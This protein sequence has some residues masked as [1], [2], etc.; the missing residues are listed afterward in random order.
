MSLDST[1]RRVPKSELERVVPFFAANLVIVIGLLAW[2][3]FLHPTMPR[4]TP[5]LAYLAI[6]GGSLH[7]VRASLKWGRLTLGLIAQNTIAV[8]LD[9]VMGCFASV[10][11]M[12]FFRSS[13][14]SNGLAV[15]AQTMIASTAVHGPAAE[16]NSVGRLATGIIVGTLANWTLP[17]FYFAARSEQSVLAI[18]QTTFNRS[19]LSAYAYYALSAILLIEVLDGSLRGYALATIVCLLGVAITDTVGEHLRVADLRGQLNQSGPFLAHS[20]EAEGTAHNLR[21]SI[22]TAVMALEGMA[23]HLPDSEGV[24]L[25]AAAQESL[26]DA[27]AQLDRLAR[28]GGRGDWSRVDV[29]SLART[30]ELLMEPIAEA[31]RVRVHVH[32]PPD[33]VWVNGNAVLLREAAVNLV[34]NAIEA[35]SRGNLVEVTVSR[36]DASALIT[37]LDQ[38]RGIPSGDEARLFAR[39]FTTKAGGSGIGLSTSHGIAREHGG[40]LTYR[41]R[42]GGGSEF[43]LRI[44]TVAG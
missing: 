3:L 15:M 39:S 9:P 12:A 37:V 21:N 6:F 29:G 2:W 27:T 17:A 34:K 8:V 1:N 20:R 44:P 26:Q 40:D 23:K 5:M 36:A 4:L 13:R 38:G 42:P 28:D 22:S 41:Q 35:S 43:T 19:W 11:S 33:P 30:V 25:A 14:P 18:W 7:W 10:F 24:R 32:A 16:L 31:A